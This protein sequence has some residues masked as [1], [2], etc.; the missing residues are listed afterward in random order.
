MLKEKKLNQGYTIPTAIMLMLL[1]FSFAV[2]ILMFAAYGYN[3]AYKRQEKMQTYLY[4]KNLVDECEYAIMDGKLNNLLSSV[5][6]DVNSNLTGSENENKYGQEYHFKL[7]LLPDDLLENSFNSEKVRLEMSIV[8]RPNATGKQLPDNTNEY[9]SVGDRVDI[10]F[11]IGKED[12]RLERVM[13]YRV[14]SEF[15]CAYDFNKNAD[16][17]LK[18]VA[19]R[20][21]DTN[22]KWQPFQYT[23]KIYTE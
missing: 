12:D 21:V 10:E 8:Y 6:N 23:G 2:G 17:T 1:L 4:A 3:N 5:V 14:L 19:D 13:E 20:E 15:Y 9:L 11:R 18:N 16:G 7:E 22:M